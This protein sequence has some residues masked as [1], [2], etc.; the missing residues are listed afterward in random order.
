R[1]I[2]FAMLMIVIGGVGAWLYFSRS[3]SEPPLP[4]MKYVS[5]TDFPGGESWP[6]F[7][8]DG[9]QIAFS[10]NGENGDNDDIYVKLIGSVKP[11]RLTTNP[12]VDYCPTWSPDGRQIAFVRISDSEIAIYT[13]PALGGAER[14]LLSVGPKWDLAYWGPTLDWSPDGKYIA[15]AEI[16]PG[17]HLPNL[18][19]FSPETGE[20]RSL[21]SPVADLDHG[22]QVFSPDGRTVAFA[23]T[24]ASLSRDI[25]L[26]SVTGGEP[27]RLTFDNA[28]LSNL[29]W[30]ADGREII[31]SSTRA[32]GE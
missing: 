23:R 5:F 3:A 12:A 2:W 16:R 4:P 1:L 24:D 8:P 26:V 19:L 9:N 30:T 10:W 17:H 22:D 11:L 28:G 31:F 27:K 18:F 29:A 14:K 25:Y 13:V 20:K 6:A 15:C 21:T 7:S 32:G